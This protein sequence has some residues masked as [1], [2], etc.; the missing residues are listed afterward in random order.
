MQNNRPFSPTNP[1]RIGGILPPISKYYYGPA[2]SPDK[3]PANGELSRY[4]FLSISASSQRQEIMFGMR[5]IQQKA[6]PYCH[7][8]HPK[9]QLPHLRP[10]N[11]TRPRTPTTAGFL[12]PH[13]L[14]YQHMQLP[15]RHT[16]PTTMV[17][18]QAPDC[19]QSTQ[20]GVKTLNQLQTLIRRGGESITIIQ[21][22][23]AHNP[24]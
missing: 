13:Q 11:G 14:L 17:P 23:N 8:V 19:H 12:G 1:Q 4:Y 9:T 24:N 22:L 7:P 15:N 6:H 20:N 2:V 21:V 5:Q 10:R 3:S 16:I 18:C